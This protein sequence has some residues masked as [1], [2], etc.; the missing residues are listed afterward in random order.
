MKKGEIVI[1]KFMTKHTVKSADQYEKFD[2]SDESDGTNRIMDL[3]PL[4]MDL[5]KGD[6]N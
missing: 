3:I 1:E 4:L 2:T 5:I 6:N